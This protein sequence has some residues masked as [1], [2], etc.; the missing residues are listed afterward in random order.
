MT[1]H[2]RYNKKSR[3]LRKSRKNRTRRRYPKYK[4]MFSNVK[5]RGPTQQPPISPNATIPCSIC[6]REFPRNEMLV[7]LTCLRKHGEK[8]HRICQDCWWDPQMGFAREDV[9]HGCPGCKK[10]LPLNP[11]IKTRKPTTEEIIII[12]D[13]DE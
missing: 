13:D 2:K 8:A 9:S 5:A 10:E 1:K 11:P 3:K 7:P 12:D 4:Q 6:G